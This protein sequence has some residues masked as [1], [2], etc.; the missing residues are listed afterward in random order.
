MHIDEFIDFVKDEYD[1]D[2]VV[3]NYYGIDRTE[4]ETSGFMQL[5]SLMGG[6]TSTIDY[7]EEDVIGVIYIE[8]F[9]ARSASECGSR[10]G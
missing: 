6:T 3:D 4:T 8:I 9:S 2:I 7:W 1:D 10:T 5:V